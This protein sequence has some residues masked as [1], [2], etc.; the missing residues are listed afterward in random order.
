MEPF[1]D[2]DLRREYVRR[3]LARA[4]ILQDRHSDAETLLLA[5]ARMVEAHWPDSLKTEAAA[6]ALATL[7]LD[8]ERPADA[9]RGRRRLP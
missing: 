4:L 8:W 2:G 7:Y 6:A 1:P 5:G 3:A 9:E